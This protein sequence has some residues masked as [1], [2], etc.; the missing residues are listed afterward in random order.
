MGRHRHPVRYHILDLSLESCHPFS[1]ST[2]ISLLLDI[3]LLPDSQRLPINILPTNKLLLTIKLLSDIKLLPAIQL[4]PTI[5]CVRHQGV[6]CKGVYGQCCS[7]RME[8]HNV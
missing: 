3:Q 4:L 2:S 7:S 8:V 5:L 1:P 6:Y